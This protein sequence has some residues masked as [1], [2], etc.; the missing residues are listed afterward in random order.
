MRVPVRKALIN[1]KTIK[2]KLFGEE[3]TLISSR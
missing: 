2:R 1:L 3:Q